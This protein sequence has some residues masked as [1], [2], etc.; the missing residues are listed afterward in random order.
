MLATSDVA[1]AYGISKATLKMWMSKNEGLMADL[2]HEGYSS[3]LRVMPPKILETFVLHLGDP[4]IY[5]KFNPPSPPETN[6]A[7]KKDMI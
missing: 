6:S 3:G 2:V 4:K 1:K 7:D 5:K